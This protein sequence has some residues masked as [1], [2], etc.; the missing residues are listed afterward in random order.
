[1]NALQAYMRGLG[2]LGDDSTNAVDMYAG[3]SIDNPLTTPITASTQPTSTVPFATPTACWPGIS[4]AS[5]PSTTAVIGPVTAQ[6]T[7]NLAIPSWVLLVVIGG[8]LLIMGTDLTSQ[9]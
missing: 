2:G 5:C 9:R 8:V 1:M 7:S 3:L 6:S 4:A